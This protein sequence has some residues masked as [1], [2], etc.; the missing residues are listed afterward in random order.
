MHVHKLF[1]PLFIVFLPRVQEILKKKIINN[2][3]KLSIVHA[4]LLH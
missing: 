2:F 4:M 1:S 3:N